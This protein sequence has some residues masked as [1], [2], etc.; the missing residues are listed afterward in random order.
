[1][2]TKRSRGSSKKLPKRIK[3][4]EFT[5]ANISENSQPDSLT[6]LCLS[7]EIDLGTTTGDSNYSDMNEHTQVTDSLNVTADSTVTSSMDHAC[8]SN[9]EVPLCSTTGFSDIPES[10]QFDPQV[11]SSTPSIPRTKIDQ[12]NTLKDLDYSQ[13][14]GYSEVTDSVNI[15]ADSSLISR[16]DQYSDSA[17][18]VEFYNALEDCLT[19][20]EVT[21]CSTTE[22][23]ENID[24]KK[25][26]KEIPTLLSHKSKSNLVPTPSANLASIEIKKQDDET[27]V[28]ICRLC[29]VFIDDEGIPIGKILPMLQI[30]LPEVDVQITK[31]PVVCQNCSSFIDKASV[32]M[33]HTLDVEN[34]IKSYHATR[35]STEEQVDLYNVLE[36]A[37]PK[38]ELDTDTFGN[39]ESKHEEIDEKKEDIKDVKRI[40]KKP[41]YKRKSVREHQKGAKY[42]Y[43]EHCTFK[44]RYRSSK[45]LH[46]KTM[47][48]NPDNIVMHSC[49]VCPFKTKYRRYLNTHMLVH[50]NPEDCKMHQCPECEY[51]TKTKSYLKTHILTHKRPEEVPKYKCEYC[52]FE[53]KHKKYLETHRLIHMDPDDIPMHQCDMCSFQTKSKQYLKTH[54]IMHKDP[55][56]IPTH[57][58]DICD[59]ETKSKQY[60]KTHKIMH[61]DPKEITMHKCEHCSFQTKFKYSLKKHVLIHRNP[62]EIPMYQCDQCTFRTRHK[63]YLETHSTVH[64]SPD[65]IPMYQCDQCEFQT[66]SKAY[67]M[68]THMQIHKN[69]DELI[70]HKCEICPF[71]TRHKGYIE[72]H[73]L[74]HKSRDEVTLYSCD[75]CDFSTKFKHY[76]RRHILVHLAPGQCP[77]YKC[78]ECDFETKHRGY[79]DTHILYVHKSKD[80][81]QMHRCTVCDFETKSKGYLKTHM[82]LHKNPDEV[83]MYKC[84]RCKFTTKHKSYLKT[85]I[86][87]MHNRKWL[88]K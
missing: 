17:Q 34:K 86:V 70:L 73:M 24:A 18:I 13:V 25:C 88:Y 16:S 33:I 85:H 14:E 59:F 47:H 81:V 75:N 52:N 60:L 74:T 48:S 76:L 58:C 45:K 77:M 9:G 61:K 35:L 12:Q 72:T 11:Q 28:K 8:I 42:Y 79:L 56:E 37:F 67:L 84:K 50:K 31:D 44:T 55:K 71:K 62:D 19:N 65:E 57:K 15:T 30:V 20:T 23:H 5:K 29:L 80:E 69:P 21:P 32:F 2:K 49:P 51:K 26:K 53:T 82:L 46:K 1:M 38:F 10:P 54:K 6:E 3:M 39:D 78:T 83:P 64:L 4:K 43:C 63:K 87:H 41:E 66:K 68:K 27:K 40:S 22:L 36:S 7:S